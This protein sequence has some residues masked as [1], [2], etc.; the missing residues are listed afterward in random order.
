MQDVLRH[1]PKYQAGDAA[2]TRIQ[3]I[4]QGEDEE[5]VECVNEGSCSQQDATGDHD[6]N[7]GMDTTYHAN[8]VHYTFQ[9]SIFDFVLDCIIYRILH[10]AYAHSHV[11]LC[12]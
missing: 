12:M 7:E 3:K 9:L 5:Q 10:L 6:G 4:L 1:M 8:E 11:L 2:L